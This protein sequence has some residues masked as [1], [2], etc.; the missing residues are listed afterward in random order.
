MSSS[1][2]ILAVLDP[3]PF[4]VSGVVSGS[5]YGMAAMGIAFTYKVS[6][7]VN[8]AYGSIA[9]FCAYVYWQIQEDWGLSVWVALPLAV[10]VV[11]T[12]LALVTERVVYRKLSSASVFAKSAAS[13]GVLLALYGI[14]L[15]FWQDLVLA[16]KLRPPTIFP[17]TKLLSING[18]NISGQQVGIVGSVWTTVLIVFVLLRFTRTGVALRA[19]V[20][21]RNLAELRGINSLASTRIAWIASYVL[22]AGAGVLFASLVGGDPLT[23]TLIVIFSLS[24]ATVGGLTSLPLTFGGGI[25]LGVL[26]SLL[27]A[28]LP[29]G[30]M[31]SQLRFSTP[32]FVMLAALM[33][34]WRAFSGQDFAENRAAVL[35][36]LAGA[37]FQRK[38]SLKLLLGRVVP[39]VIIPGVILQVVSYGYGLSL[40]TSGVAFGIIFLSY[41]V[42]TATTGIVSFAQAAFAGIGAFATANFLE[43]GLPWPLACGGG[44]VV[45]GASGILLAL[46]T[47]RL[48][49][50]FLTLASIAFA[51]LV[52]NVVFTRTSFTGGLTG[53]SMPRPAGFDGDFAYFLLLVAVFCVAGY[54]CERFQYSSA[55]LEL[56]A[57][58]GSS[59]GAQSIGIRPE[60]GRVISF[61]LA[62][63]L[64][65]LGGTFL[66]AQTE[67]LSPNT[68]GLIPAFLWLVLVASGGLGSTSMMVQIGVAVAVLPALI[69]SHV[70]ALGGQTYVALFGLLGLLVLRVPGGAV[71][72]EERVAGWLHQRLA[73]RSAEAELTTDPEPTASERN[74]EVLLQPWVD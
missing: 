6:R 31:W 49:G 64:A 27:L 70:P 16:G 55:G 37:A 46:P 60:R 43:S 54:L 50:I 38:P 34:R 11:P 18:V 30:T 26:S 40:L 52:E 7:V 3:T 45:A 28:Y 66:A 22:A 74:E 41:R 23:L 39:I 72:I 73:G 71:G 29:S 57:E 15:Y 21:N 19:T 24:A 47:V 20:V 56:Q 36:D 59:A 44:A 9:M 13:I 32:F 10:L 12:L 33:I 68:W 63:S 1:S 69:E 67:F 61:A 42:F 8:F 14:S 51:M 25:A 2:S 35:H 4:I 65:G 17:R 5:V 58:L 53:K 62:A 48:R